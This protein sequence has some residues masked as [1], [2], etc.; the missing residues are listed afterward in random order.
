VNLILFVLGL[1]CGGTLT[2]AVIEWV[3]VLDEKMRD[4]GL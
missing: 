4:A 1:I 2:L 3:H